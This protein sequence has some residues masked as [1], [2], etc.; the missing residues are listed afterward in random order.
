MDVGVRRRRGASARRLVAGTL[1]ALMLLLG[2]PAVPA[3]GATSTPR[4]QLLWF[5]DRGDERITIGGNSGA[6]ISMGS[7]AFECDRIFPTADVYVVD[8][9]QAD[10][11]ILA[12]LSG[13][14]NTV[15]GMG[16]GLILDELIAVSAPGG[17]L[18]PGTYSVVYDECQDGRFNRSVDAYFE[19][20]ITVRAPSGDVPP[21]PDALGLLK[22]RAAIQAAYW[23]FAANVYYV[24]HNIDELKAAILC[25]A[26]PNAACNLQYALSNLQDDLEESA[27]EALGVADPEEVFQDLLFDQTDHYTGIALDPPDPDFRRVTTLEPVRTPPPSTSG[28]ALEQAGGRAAEASATNAVLAQALLHSLERY[29]G[30]DAANDAGWALVHARQIQAFSRLLATHQNRSNTALAGL[31]AA[32]ATDGVDA[33]RVA[34]YVTPIQ[35]RVAA[36]GWN[37]EE[38]RLLRNGGLPT[39][40]IDALAA[41]TTSV[42][43]GSDEALTDAVADLRTSSTAFAGTLT[44]LVRSVDGLVANLLANNVVPPAPPTAGPGGPYTVG[45]GAPLVLDGR[46][47]RGDITSYAWDID[48]DGAFDDANG[49]RPTVTAPA[50]RSGLVG[51]QVNGPSGTAVG[52]AQLTVTDTDLPPTLVVTPAANDLHVAAGA[53]L[54]LVATATDPQ[55]QPVTF[56]WAVDGVQ[57]AT[58][59]TFSYRPT[60]ADVGSHDVRVVV[61]DGSALGGVTQAARLVTVDAPDVDGD[62]W[63]GSVDCDDANAAVHPDAREIE[64]NG[65]DDDCDPATSDAVVDDPPTAGPVSTGVLEDG[66]IAIPLAGDDPEGAP[67]TYEVLTLPTKG[68]LGPV[69]G[70]EVTY[71]AGPDATG[72]D[73][74]T[75]RVSDGGL[76]SAEA[77]VTIAIAPVA[78]APVAAAGAASTDEEVPVTIPLTGADPDGGALTYAVAAPPGKGSLTI[79]G[80]SAGYTP[81]PNSNGTDTFTFTVSDGTTTSEPAT[82]TVTVAPVNDRPVAAPVSVTTPEDTPVV[83]PLLGSDFDGDALRAIVVDDPAR[84]VLSGSGMSLTYSPERDVSGP[85]HL[86]LRGDRRHDGLGPGHRH[87]DG[88]PGQR[89]ARGRGRHRPRGRGR[90]HGDLHGGQRCRA[91]AADVRRRQ[92]TEPRRARPGHG[93]AGHLHP[94]SRV[95]RCRLVH[96]PGLGRHRLLPGAHGRHHRQRRERLPRGPR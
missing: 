2:S 47:S 45:E 60:I 30:A 85:F 63:R 52:Y 59:A 29:Q 10:G 67:L 65:L 82:V 28:T 39:A 27:R 96:L 11:E 17:R 95:R 92:R 53:Q 16:G 8:G 57:V 37:D 19:N 20:A 64:G 94:G 21:L 46:S 7:V 34:A 13:G 58:T 26:I 49:V 38:T 22:S 4:F 3:Q 1:G 86:H 25:L 40:E 80:A 66:S 84:G 77:T 33:G 69:T 62:G 68:T 14:K 81:A 51:L 78:D 74:F 15:I 43:G 87:G 93:P 56:R 70:G 89:S 9:P 42:R 41:S 83:V 48:G 31:A 35:E 44:S 55:A 12:D 50:A 6:F 88:Q 54:N 91:V 75:Y 5:N 18:G 36:S 24:Y 61:S 72:A 90:A 23:R 71:T 76:T 73:A 32:A 79:S